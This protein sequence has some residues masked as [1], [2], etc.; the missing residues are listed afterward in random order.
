MIENYNAIFDDSFNFDNW[1]IDYGFVIIEKNNFETLYSINLD[2]N[3][4][5]VYVKTT[6]V[7][8]ELIISDIQIENLYKF[9]SSEK[10][11]EFIKPANELFAL[12]YLEHIF[13]YYAYNS[14]TD[15]NSERYF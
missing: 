12:H 14:K 1:L 8:F 5:I 7:I 11:V 3:K 15:D 13:I 10:T 6:A 2:F 4:Q 9:N